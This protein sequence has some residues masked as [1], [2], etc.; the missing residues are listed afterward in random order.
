[1]TARTDVFLV[2][3]FLGSGKTTLLNRLIRAFPAHARPV[4]L[5]NEFGDVGVDG[6]LVEDDDLEILEISKG[7]IFCVCV[8]TDF[9][10]GLLRI[11]AELRP[12][13]LVIEATGVA[14]PTA[15]KKDLALSV[16]KGRFRLREQLCVIDALNFRDA[17]DTFV[18][19]EKQIA[20]ATRFVINKIDLATPEMIQEIKAVVRRHHPDPR[21]QECAYGDIPASSLHFDDP[22][23]APENQDAEID[24]EAAQAAVDGL[25]KEPLPES[26]PPDPLASA[27]YEWR[28]DDPSGLTALARR[29]PAGIVR[30]K[31]L[32][33]CGDDTLL[34]SWVLGAAELKT[35]RPSKKT[36]P[37]VSDVTDRVVFIG[38][39]SALTALEQA[40]RN[41][42][43]ISRQPMRKP[44]TLLS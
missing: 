22:E 5:M 37:A 43:L 34:F 38:T 3:G 19:V 28:G 41:S 26:L 2:T 36:N 17:Y 42:V 33:A 31:G 39:S 11:A 29:F 10:R 13:V 25:F 12:D 4:I 23:T 18:S 6:R 44:F 8:K 15:M 14:D 7:S 20:S 9:I 27:V 24:P 21:F 16:F 35:V 40:M 30:A 1:M 32:L